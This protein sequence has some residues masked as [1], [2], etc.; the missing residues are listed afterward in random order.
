MLVTGKL[1]PGHIDKFLEAFKPLVRWMCLDQVSVQQR[2]HSEGQLAI[3]CGLQLLL[4][5][6][7]T[8]SKH[9]RLDMIALA[10]DQAIA[11]LS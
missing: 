2:S 3:A 11:W 7:A 6:C 9:A 10:A 5:Q 1:A 8:C 4:I